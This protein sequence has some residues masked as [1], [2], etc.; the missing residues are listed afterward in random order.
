[1]DEKSLLGAL[2]RNLAS[3]N[4]DSK[5]LGD[6]AGRL[7]RSELA[8]RKIDPCV[9][10]ICIDFDWKH[11]VPKLDLSKVTDIFPGGIKQIEIFPYGILVDEGAL[12]RVSA[13]F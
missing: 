2:T 7:G 10:G 6:V 4:F 3:R 12:V 8:I 9:Y 11:P 1:M 13:S 5:V